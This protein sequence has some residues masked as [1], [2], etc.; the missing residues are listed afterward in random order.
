MRKDTCDIWDYYEK[1]YR[2]VV[3]TNLGWDVGMTNNMGAGLALQTARRFPWLPTWY[4]AE[5]YKM[6]ENQQ[7]LVIP[8]NPLRLIFLPVKP[9]LIDAP[10]MSWNQMADLGLI[11]RG[12]ENLRN[13]FAQ[14][15]GAV[16]IAL[17][18]ALTLPGCGNGGLH[19]D[20]VLPLV[21]KIFASY[22]TV[23]LCDQAL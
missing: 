11:K 10:H 4:G 3:T 15:G 2:I 16:P 22:N 14:K 6:A 18:I 23:V 19:R 9:L 20:Q 21:E 17:P 7:E 1:G 5:C 8:F 12:L 13:G